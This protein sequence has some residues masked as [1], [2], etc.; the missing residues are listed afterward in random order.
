MT[1]A[2]DKS[3]KRTLLSVPPEIKS[4]VQHVRL[5]KAQLRTNADETQTVVLEVENQAYVDVIAISLETSKKGQGKYEVVSSGFSPNK[6]PLVII[7]SRGV[8][9]L[10]FG[11]FYAD[12]PLKLGSVIYADGTEEGCAPSLK[13]VHEVKERKLRQKKESN[14]E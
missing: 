9:T 11:N 14:P 13:S 12:E 8:K 2:H 4:C 6:D 7:P 5:V 3:P 1:L 10:E